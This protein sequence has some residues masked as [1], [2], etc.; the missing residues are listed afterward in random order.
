MPSRSQRQRPGAKVIKS[1]KDVEKGKQHKL[2]K[3]LAGAADLERQLGNIT[4]T[5]DDNKPSKLRSHLCEVLTEILLANPTFASENHCFQRLWRGCFYKPISIWRQ[6]VSREKRKRSPNLATSQEGFKFFL[7]EAIKLYD[8]L[9]KMYLEKLCPVSTQTQTQLSQDSSVTFESSQV[10]EDSLMMNGSDE[11][12]SLLS[13]VNGDAKS[14][15]DVVPGLYK[16]Y[17]FLGDLHRYAEAYNKAEINY[18]NAS[19]LGPGL[20]NPYNQLAVVAFSKEAYC[21]SLYWY[22]RSLLATHEKFST[23]SSNLERLF[24]TNRDFLLEHGRD[25][26]PTMFSLNNDANNDS[27]NSKK[28]SLNN[29][30]SSSM[31][32]AKKACCSKSC[33][34]HFVD[35]HY[36]LYQHQKQEKDLHDDEKEEKLKKKMKN[37]IASLKSLVQASGFSDSLLCKILVI[38][39]FSLERA[40]TEKSFSSPISQ[41]LSKELFYSVGLV[42]TEHIEGNLMKALVKASPNKP[43]PSIRYLLPLEMI[44]EFI[45]IGIDA[46][47]KEGHNLKTN[48]ATSITEDK[49]WKYVLVVGNLVQE[50]VKKY[51]I[52][53]QFLDDPLST[54][55]SQKLYLQI[56]EYQLLKGYRPFSTVNEEYMSNSKDGFIEPVEAVEVLELSLTQKSQDTNVLS[57]TSISTGGGGINENKAKL[58]RTLEIC[59]SLASSNSTVPLTINDDDGSFVYKQYDPSSIIVMPLTSNN[60]DNGNKDN[61]IGG[62]DDGT[63]E[64]EQGGGVDFDVQLN[65]DYDDEA[66]D[67]IVYKSTTGIIGK[68]P[69]LREISMVASCPV[70]S[71]T[72]A[73]KD[74]LKVNQT[75]IDAT[76][77]SPKATF[78]ASG[79]AI[80]YDQEDSINTKHQPSALSKI[81]PPP[82]FGGSSTPMPT[83]PGQTS[84]YNNPVTGH[85]I[86]VATNPAPG[87][88]PPNGILPP[89]MQSLTPTE[90]SSLFHLP[91]QQQQ[92]LIPGL[93]L[94]QSS[95]ALYP[96]IIGSELLNNKA[97]S[98]RI[99]GDMQTAN[100]FVAVDPPVSPSFPMLNPGVYQNSTVPNNNYENNTDVTNFLNAGLLNSLWMDESKT[101]NPWAGK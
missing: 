74:K 77:Q 43:A 100:P 36:D 49:F 16:L 2:V 17:I 59:T 70:F 81:K 32:R 3:L 68:S 90:S 64:M 34:T 13:S 51:K 93:N 24:T 92:S 27:R 98:V 61:E 76:Q 96:L 19:K 63:E 94:P 45:K 8:C 37:V 14:V 7:S 101:N 69:Q 54:T 60:N 72:T 31:V 28:S 40:K 86:K 53:E 82:G 58:F 78:A 1:P 57:R 50:T 26:T 21:V 87:L 88:L 18:L 20:G 91:Q 52:E 83:L 39:I 12:D 84:T 9:V 29:S 67:V 6:Q 33:L 89:I 95:Q 44:L 46:D 71:V 80:T 47:N 79:V 30:S 35:L 25:S 62:D 38:N 5:N 55:L 10:I 41:R 85:M 65:N 48:M 23:S 73:G 56:K 66:G 22:T 99:F 97:D 42:L 11:S 75:D 15:E 4:A